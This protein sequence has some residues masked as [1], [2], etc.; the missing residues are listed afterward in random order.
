M[1]RMRATRFLGMVVGAA[2]Y[3][4][5]EQALNARRVDYRS[6]IYI[7]SRRDDNGDVL[8][9]RQVSTTSCWERNAGNTDSTPK[10][11][12]FPSC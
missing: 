5:P 4:A 6:D 1:T 11:K 7:I 10:A 3:I 12:N 2:D 8:L 9:A